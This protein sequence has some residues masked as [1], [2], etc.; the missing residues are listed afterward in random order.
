MNVA[1]SHESRVGTQEVPKPVPLLLRMREKI[2]GEV[3]GNSEC[4]DHPTYSGATQTPHGDVY[5]YET[6]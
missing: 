2:S 3:D 1:C 4:G 5:D 6:D